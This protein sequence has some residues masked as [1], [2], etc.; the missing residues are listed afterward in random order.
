M[1]RLIGTFA[2]APAWFV[3]LHKLGSL[4]CVNRQ[5]HAGNGRGCVHYS[6]SGFDSDE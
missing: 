1:K 2:D 4:P 6:T 5:P 3:C